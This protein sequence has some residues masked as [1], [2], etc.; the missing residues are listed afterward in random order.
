MTEAFAIVTPVKRRYQYIFFNEAYKEIIS[1]KLILVAP[2]T[3]VP[4]QPLTAI[5]VTE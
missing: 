4:V 5:A 3:A 1:S 2:A